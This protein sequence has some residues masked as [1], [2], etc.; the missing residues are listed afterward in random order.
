M[1]LELSTREVKQVWTSAFLFGRVRIQVLM[2]ISNLSKGAPVPRSVL[3]Q[4]MI[5]YWIPV[6]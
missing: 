1:N 5:S 4:R 2:F 6:K 3:E